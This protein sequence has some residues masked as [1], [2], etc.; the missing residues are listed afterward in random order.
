MSLTAYA[1]DLDNIR[2]QVTVTIELVTPEV[3]IDWLGYNTRNRRTKPAAIAKYQRD[4]VAGNWRFTGEAIKFG[5]DGRLLDGQNRLHAVIESEIPVVMLVVRGLHPKSQGA[6]DSGVKR[7]AAA[8]LDLLGEKYSRKLAAAAVCITSI[9]AD[10]IQSLSHS[11]IAAIVEGDPSIRWIVQEVLPP[12]RLSS[13]L[14]P[15]VAAYVYWKLN[16]ISP[17]DASEFFT[18]LSTLADLSVGS[19]ILVLD[20]VLR[21]D[22]D[23]RNAGWMARQR[24]VARVFRA[25]NHWRAGQTVQKIVVHMS[26]FGRVQVPEPK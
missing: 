23:S 15:A 1:A 25:W 17:D 14:A 24:T 18:S 5:T 9:E 26:G 11:E 3:A 13:V 20:R 12:L 4:Q 8:S 16:K 10:C 21:Q 6:M 19:P 7:D 2:D 22:K